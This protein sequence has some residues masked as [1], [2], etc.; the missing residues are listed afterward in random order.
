MFTNPFDNNKVILED[1][2]SEFGS[3]TMRLRQDVAPV[4]NPKPEVAS[5]SARPEESS[6]QTN[7][8]GSTASSRTKIEGLDYNVPFED[9]YDLDPS[10]PRIPWWTDRFNEMRALG[11]I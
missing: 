9:I 8:F 7:G 4:E 11:V 5:D 3:I 6:N 1:T 2:W 10:D